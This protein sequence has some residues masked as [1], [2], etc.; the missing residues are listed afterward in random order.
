MAAL[1]PNTFVLLSNRQAAMSLGDFEIP[2]GFERPNVGHPK[3][4]VLGLGTGRRSV[5]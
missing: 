5:E 1:V 2:V 4:L 3:H